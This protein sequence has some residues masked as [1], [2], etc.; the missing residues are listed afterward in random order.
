MPGEAAGVGGA[1]GPD[2]VRHD[3]LPARRDADHAEGQH[4]RTG[5]QP[6]AQP[7]LVEPDRLDLSGIV[8]E[9]DEEAGEP[10]EVVEPGADDPPADRAGLP[11]RRGTDRR[12]A[13]PVDVFAREKVQ[14]IEEGLDAEALEELGLLRADAL[15]EL[16]G[17]REDVIA[18][19][20]HGRN[21][22][23]D[24]TLNSSRG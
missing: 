7:R 14:E 1:S 13:R 19:G 21:R 10:V 16:D 22:R 8:G 4:L 3:L 6:L 2:P 9:D 18:G 5:R 12:E 15:Q 17:C 23:R 24:K 20:R 11:G